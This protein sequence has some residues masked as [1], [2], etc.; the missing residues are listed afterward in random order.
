MNERQRRKSDVRVATNAFAVVWQLR[1]VSESGGL[2][3]SSVRRYRNTIDGWQGPTRAARWIAVSVQRAPFDRQ[4]SRPTSVLDVE[5]TET[6]DGLI[7]LF[8]F[9]VKKTGTV[10]W[11]WA[12]QALHGEGLV[13]TSDLSAPR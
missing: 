2:T 11:I 6:E 5:L 8:P 13:P 9:L 10:R 4:E 12:R 1:W 3:P 7:G